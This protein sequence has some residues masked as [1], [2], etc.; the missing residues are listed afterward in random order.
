LFIIPLGLT[1]MALPIAP[2]GLGVGQVVFY[3]L[4]SD[5]VPGSGSLGASMVTIYQLVYVFVSLTGIFFYLSESPMR[6]SVTF[7]NE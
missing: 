5:L 1:A 6:R 3:V 2:A 4:F 7:I